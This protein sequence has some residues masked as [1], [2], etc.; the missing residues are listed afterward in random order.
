MCVAS[1]AT[2]LWFTMP[3][4]ATIAFMGLSEWKFKDAVFPVILLK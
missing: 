3:R 4:L 2:G 1:I